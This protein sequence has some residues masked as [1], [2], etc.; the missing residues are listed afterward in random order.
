M[1]K[2][3]NFAT[4]LLSLI[5]INLAFAQFQVPPTYLPGANMNQPNAANK[6]SGNAKVNKRE[7]INTTSQQNELD[8][9]V[10]QRKSE[11]ISNQTIE[12]DSIKKAKIALQN[13]I[14]GFSIFNKKAG[15]F[16]TNLKMATPKIT[17]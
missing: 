10:N 12:E 6:P 14:F 16:E 17:Y 8:S 13:K 5:S 4:V 7:I 11:A 1:I 3:I 9:L 2:K 15:I